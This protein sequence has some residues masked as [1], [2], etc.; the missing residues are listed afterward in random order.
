MEQ[1]SG[2]QQV[3]VFGFVGQIA[4]HIFDLFA[5]TEDVLNRHEGMLID[6]IAVIEIADHQR[7]HF[8]QFGKQRLQNAG[9]MHG[10]E[11]L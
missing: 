7:F 10:A 9:V 1:Q 2:N 6:R 3:Q 5:Q 8:A 11:G 4:E